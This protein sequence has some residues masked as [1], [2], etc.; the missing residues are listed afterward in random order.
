MVVFN[1][2]LELELLEATYRLVLV[3]RFGKGEWRRRRI[4]GRARRRASRL[5]RKLLDEW[6]R[7]LRAMNHGIVELHEVVD[8]IPGVMARYGFASYDAAHAAT[9]GRMRVGGMVT[10]DTGFAAIPSSE[11][12][13]FVGARQVGRCRS[14]RAGSH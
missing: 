6:T 7:V 12:E 1:R 11:L 3:E 14:L 13:L 5:V 4:D 10:L 8:E 9:A 2:L